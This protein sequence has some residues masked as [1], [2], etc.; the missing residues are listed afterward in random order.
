MYSPPNFEEMG[1]ENRLSF[2]GL[3][4]V[5]ASLSGTKGDFSAD[6]VNTHLFLTQSVLNL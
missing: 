3:L 2:T 5:L 4:A 6:F 1:G